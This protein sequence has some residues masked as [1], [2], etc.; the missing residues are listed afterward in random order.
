MPSLAALLLALHAAPHA[1]AADDDGLTLRAAA[2]G[3]AASFDRSGLRL[4]PRG[5]AR[6][7]TLQTARV[8]CQGALTRVRARALADERGRATLEHQLAGGRLSE[9]VVTGPGGLEHG[10]TVP[11]PL[12]CRARG[13]E[14]IIV[15]VRLA[16]GYRAEVSAD[17]R[18]ALLRGAGALVR[19]TDLHAVDARGRRLPARLVA[20]SGH[21]QLHVD[22]RGA[23]YPITIDPL[24]ANQEA[25]LAADDPALGDNFGFSVAIDGATAIAGVPFDDDNGTSSGSARVFVESGGVWSQQAKLTASDAASNDQFGYAVALVGDVAAV[26]APFE[27]A[28]G[29][30]AGAVYVFTRTGDV[31]SEHSKLV[32]ADASS[33]DEFAR[34]IALSGD[35]L[36]AGSRGDDDVAMN[37]GAAYVYALVGDAWTEQAKLTAPDG[38]AGE[39]FGWAVAVDGDVA[40]VGAPDDGEGGNADYGSLNVFTRAADVWSHQIKLEASDK[41]VNA[42]LGESVAVRDGIIVGGAPFDSNLGAVYVFESQTMLE[43]AKLVPGDAASG[44]D[45]G[46]SVSTDNK[47]IAAGSPDD[48]DLGSNSG[49][50]YVFTP[51]DKMWVQAI[52]F[53]PLDGGPGDLFATALAISGPSV[54]GSAHLNDDFE[55]NTGSAYVFRLAF[56]QG[57]PCDADE[58]CQTGACVDGVC[59]DDPCGGGVDD[60]QACS[61]EKGATK[62]GVCELLAADVECRPAAGGCDEPEVCDG[63]NLECPEDQFAPPDIICREIAGDCDIEE[64]CS[65][66]HPDCP[67]DSVLTGVEC[68]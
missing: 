65:G 50:T 12:P 26:G 37:A 22:D 44:D 19:Y 30:N 67:D 32:P 54:I 52:K 56:D 29:T 38:E 39:N 7:L 42:R 49:S 15:E 57:D 9:W 60:C 64:I 66:I 4:R 3:L 10:Y 47:V 27:D 45:F 43:L 61:V 25:K 6:D 14:G 36:I 23:V 33:F 24:L 46:K 48:D 40:V 17:G 58:D 51:V 63:V 2:T 20:R 21:L 68:R 28:G 8:G 41:Q 16:G 59:C 55:A 53:Q 13:G 34:S 62:D 18:G 35:T 1:R 11:R 5:A 31:W